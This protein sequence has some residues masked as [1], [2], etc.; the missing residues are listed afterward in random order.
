[1]IS[2]CNLFLFHIG[3]VIEI[4]TYVVFVWINGLQFCDLWLYTV[5]LLRLLHHHYF[6]HCAL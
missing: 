5:S 1:M 6:F 3:H 4:F 2:V